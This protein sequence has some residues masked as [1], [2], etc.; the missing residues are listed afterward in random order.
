MALLRRGSSGISNQNFDSRLQREQAMSG[1]VTASLAWNDPSDLD[2]HAHVRLASGA[3]EHVCYR[4]KQ[5]AGGVLDVDMH[6]SEDQIV[7]EPVENI[8]WEHPPAGTYSIRVNVYKRR[9]EVDPL[10]FRALLKREGQED[11]S[12]EGELTR[13]RGTLE[14]FRFT[15]DADGSIEVTRAEA[16]AVAD[17]APTPLPFG[18][19]PRLTGRRGRGVAA[20]ARTPAVATKARRARTSTVAR[21]KKAMLLVFEGKKVR[22]S[23]GLR[24]DDLTRGKKGKVVS[25]K[26]HR[27]GKAN[28]WAQ[29]TSMARA[30]KGFSG[31]RV[32]RK[33]GSFY[34]KT[35]EIFSTL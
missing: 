35:R 10:R 6:A 4:H 3:S 17:A 30:A 16:S 2:L 27:L 34:E 25:L 5:G 9:S 20:A 11:L 23:S 21:G 1:A 14:C 8:F 22:T 26:K 31:F 24:K 18:G 12:V 29:A 13:A 7:R 28:K 33:G 15:V 32:L 19:A